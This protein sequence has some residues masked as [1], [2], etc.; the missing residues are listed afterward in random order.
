MY[1]EK[2][3]PEYQTYYF[4]VVMAKKAAKEY[5]SK[6]ILKWLVIIKLVNGHTKIMK[7]RCQTVSFRMS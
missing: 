6:L 1:L 3:N 7:A 5:V 4:T 2:N